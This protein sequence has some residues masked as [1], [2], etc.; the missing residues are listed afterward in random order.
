MEGILGWMNGVLGKGEKCPGSFLLLRYNIKLKG[1]VRLE[2]NEDVSL[3]KWGFIAL[4]GRMK[5]RFIYVD[6]QR[7]AKRT[8]RHH[9]KLARLVPFLHH[10]DDTGLFFHTLLTQKRAIY[11]S[12]KKVKNIFNLLEI[13]KK[14]IVLEK[15]E[16]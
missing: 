13:K 3:T 8:D 15:I 4:F 10:P 11:Q 6:P 9:N 14:K 12:N 1:Q 7:A 2:I 5:L 16:K